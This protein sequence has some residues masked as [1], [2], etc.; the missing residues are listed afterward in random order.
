M[1][2]K[3]QI[4]KN[5]KLKAHQKLEDIK[6]FNKEDAN[7]ELQRIIAEAEA[8]GY[9][10]NIKRIGNQIHIDKIKINNKT[11]KIVDGHFWVEHN[12]QNIDLTT[13]NLIEAMKRNGHRCVY[14]PA[15]QPEAD[16]FINM[17]YDRLKEKHIAK[18]GI[19]EEWLED[20]T[21]RYENGCLNSFDCVA[22]AMVLKNK[23]GDNAKIVYGQ[24]GALK[25]DG[26]IHWYF[27]HPDEPPTLWEKDNSKEMKPEYITTLTPASRFPNLIY[28][29]RTPELKPKKNKK[30]KINK[31]NDVVI[32]W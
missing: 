26:F 11:E 27:G 3:Q 12:G 6:H 24:V 31:C 32:D 4:I 23:L 18:G 21:E 10:C 17:V 28:D 9:K 5:L 29:P 7:A 14:L 20:V 25:P 15:P 30:R 22:G 19:W 13:D 16:Q 2:T 8:E 1:A